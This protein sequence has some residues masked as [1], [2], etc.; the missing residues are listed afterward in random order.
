MDI[1]LSI[2]PK[3]TSFSVLIINDL[4]TSPLPRI[5][6]QPFYVQSFPIRAADRKKGNLDISG[7]IRGKAK[8]AMELTIAGYFNGDNKSLISI[9]L[10]GNYSNNG[11]FIFKPTYLFLKY[12]H[13]FKEQEPEK[14]QSGSLLLEIAV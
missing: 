14:L 7:I 1:T 4:E 6:G 12:H 9:K 5:P 10:S 13:H 8:T 11:S 3:N 2:S